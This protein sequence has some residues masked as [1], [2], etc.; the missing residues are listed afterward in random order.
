[1][2]LLW[3]GGHP[4]QL[5]IDKVTTSHSCNKKGHLSRVCR[6]SNSH[7]RKTTW[8]EAELHSPQDSSENAKVDLIYNVG[9]KASHHYQVVVQVNGN[10]ITMEID[11]CAAVSKSHV[12]TSQVGTEVTHI[13][14]PTYSCGGPD[15]GTREVPGLCR[16]H[17]LHVVEGIP[18]GP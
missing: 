12:S 10:P 15:E 14:S 13:H 16:Q 11:T 7:R 3:E 6:S 5:C 8:V 18:I 17:K 9:R 1:M 4:P 2:L